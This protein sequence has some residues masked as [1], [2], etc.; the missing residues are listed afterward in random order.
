VFT[1][2]HSWFAGEGRA[3]FLIRSVMTILFAVTCP[4]DGNATIVFSS[5][6]MLSSRAICSTGLVIWFQDKVIWT[7]TCVTSGRIEKA[8]M[9]AASIV[10]STWIPERKLPEWVIDVNVVRTMTGISQDL[11]VFP[12][13][14]VSSEES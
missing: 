9:T 4:V 8:E 14:L 6:T 2:E 11:Q 12:C 3:V 10:V 13:E 1:L 5:T 7:T